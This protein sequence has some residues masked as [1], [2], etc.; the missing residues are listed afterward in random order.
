MELKFNKTNQENPVM[1]MSLTVPQLQ[2]EQELEALLTLE[3]LKR[4][5]YLSVE[6]A[7]NT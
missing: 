1:N 6:P 3:G 4:E 5:L 7:M 2:Q